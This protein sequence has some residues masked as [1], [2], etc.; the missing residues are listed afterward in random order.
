MTSAVLLVQALGGGWDRSALPERPECC[1]RLTGN[2]RQGWRAFGNVAGR[3]ERVPPMKW[4]V[5][6]A[7]K[8]FAPE[9]S[10]RKRVAY[11]LAIARL[12]LV[13]VIFLAVYYLFAMG[14][15]V[16]R[17]VNVDAPA[18]KLAE[19]ASVETLEA[20]REVRNYILFQSPEYLQANQATLTKLRQ[21]LAR[22][23]NLE[24]DE[25]AMVQKGLDAVTQYQ[26][27]FAAAVS[28]MAKSGQEPEDRVREALRAYE[29]D[30][31]DLGKTARHEKRGQL[32]QELRTRFGS[33]DTQ[34]T[35]AI[36]EADPALRPVTPDLRTTSQEIL[37]LTSE[38]EQQNWVRVEMD[39]Q[40]ARQLIHR[41]EWALSIVSA[42]ALLFSVWV[43]IVLPRQV[44]QPLVSLKEA[45]DHAATGNY[46][47]EFELHGTGEVAELAKSVQNLTSLLRTKP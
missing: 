44:V 24:P 18:A 15:I 28:T 33:F 31:E 19:Q 26:H 46:E 36:Q 38:L 16:D 30:L 42:I 12:I 47:V 41:A 37:Q 8:I 35:E 17:I 34:I 29:K 2:S 11:S 39:H 10:L 25:Q 13:P 3:F 43:S 9:S 14:W 45:V 1:G 40:E 6:K 20:R 7:F 5:R 27:G 23:G 32:I 22:I 4:R 21:I